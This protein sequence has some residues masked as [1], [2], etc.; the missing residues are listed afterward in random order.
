MDLHFTPRRLT[1]LAILAA[2]SAILYYIPGI[3]IVPPMYKLDFS[4]VPI[5]ICALISGPVDAV[6]ALI[7][8]DLT[9]LFHSSSVG[10]GELADLVCS[11]AL[12]VTAFFVSRPDKKHKTIS[13]VKAMVL[14]I[15]AMAA[16]GALVNYFIMIP[17][18]VKVMH[19]PLSTIIDMVNDLLPSV[20]SLPRL[21]AYATVPFNLIKGIVICAIAYPVYNQL[22]EYGH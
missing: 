6:F 16:A 21:I 12:C 11:A 13:L 20:S 9:G 15:L 19:W 22:R 10:V 4:T 7:F 3:P 2:L 18:Y 14:G 1:R 17:F 8:K 5:L